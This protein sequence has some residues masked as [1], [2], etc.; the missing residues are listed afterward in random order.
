MA[1][2]CNPRDWRDRKVRD[3]LLLLLIFA[4]TLEA[5][6]QSAALAAAHE[7]DGLGVRWRRTTPGFFVRTSNELC[8]AIL[9][10][11][12]GANPVLRKHIARIDDPRL[13]R[14]F[15]AAVALQEVLEM[16]RES[17]RPKRHS[18]PHLWKGL[19]AG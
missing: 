14:A 15:R 17:V 18:V 3:W 10:G 2:T 6:E 7:L 13:R 8:Q 5:K 9:A 19:P 12:H 1:A 4:V 16:G 11:D